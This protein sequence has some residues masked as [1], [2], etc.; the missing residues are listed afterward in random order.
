MLLLLH[1]RLLPS[2]GRAQQTTPTCPRHTAASPAVVL[3]SS[4]SSHSGSLCCSH[5]HLKHT[6]L[7]FTAVS[8]H[9]QTQYKSVIIIIMVVVIT[10]FPG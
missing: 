4:P 10:T 3:P 7:Q 8:N 2:R 1:L 5:T 9:P 6:Q